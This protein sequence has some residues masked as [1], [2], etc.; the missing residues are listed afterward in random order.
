MILADRIIRTLANADLYGRMR[1]FHKIALIYRC[2]LFPAITYETN[3]EAEQHC[4]SIEKLCMRITPNTAIPPHEMMAASL[5]NRGILVTVGE[6]NDCLIFNAPFDENLIIAATFIQG[7][8]A[9]MC[10]DAGDAELLTGKKR[11]SYA[12]SCGY[13]LHRKDLPRTVGQALLAF[14]HNVVPKKSIGGETT[15]LRHHL[16]ICA[17]VIAS[18]SG[19]DT[20]EI[21]DKIRHYVN[22]GNNVVVPLKDIELVL[23]DATLRICKNSSLATLLW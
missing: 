12:L 23:S 5:K 10:L 7:N 3:E 16:G 9:G 22:T 19:L 8:G 17:R 18:L 2:G 14:Q 21:G 15:S 20:A 1:I 4:E 6:F 13:T 11:K